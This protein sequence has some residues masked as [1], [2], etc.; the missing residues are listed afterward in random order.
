MKNLAL[1]LLVVS[2]LAH[3]G[4]LLTFDAPGSNIQGAPGQTVFWNFQLSNDANYLLIDQVDYLSLN[5]A[6]V[7]ADLFSAVAPVIGPGDV[8]SGSSSYTI[9]GPAPIGYLSTG[10]F[11]ITYD[12][13]LMDPNDPNFD[14]DRDHVNTDPETVSS[15]ASVLVSTSA[16]PEP[17]TLMLLLPGA[18]YLLIR[19]RPLRVV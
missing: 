15:A 16:V 14:Y 12:E 7:F 18:L 11:V 10:Q 4:T 9:D 5:N 8:V 17:G 1:L 3:A 6:G 2:G 19:K 13:F